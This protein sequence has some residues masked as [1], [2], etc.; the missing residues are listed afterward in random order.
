MKKDLKNFSDLLQ[1]MDRLREECPWD[2]EQTMLSLRNNTVEEC[3]E[4]TDA[5]LSGDMSAIKEELGDLLLHIVFYAKIAEEQGAFD[6]ED[7]A[8]SLNDKLV[9]R[10]PHVFG[11]TVADDTRQVMQNWEAL[12]QKKKK[13]GGTLSG[14]PSGMPALPKA[15][16]IGQK[17]ASAGF[18]WQKREDVW[19][20]VKEE[21]F[22]LEHEIK[23]Y[24]LGIKGCEPVG[25]IPNSQFSALTSV[26]DEFGDLYFSLTN[27][28]RLY[29]VDP[30]AA[31]ERTNQKFA[32]RFGYVE[33]Q[34][35]QKGLSL[36]DMPL[37]EMDIYWEEAKEQERQEK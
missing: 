11:D 22:E 26:E 17:A 2:R 13:E 25:S 30:E 23:S 24:E 34:V 8:K 28:A 19:E 9:Y 32:R 5:I 31:L 21:L 1:I 6:L 12:K 37:P 27:A 36:Q 3:F 7:V 10:H 15:L 33:A 29:G 14:V 20:K 16:R 18:D 4:L 35:Q